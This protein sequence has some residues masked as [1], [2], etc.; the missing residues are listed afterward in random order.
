MNVN[1]NKSAGTIHSMQSSNWIHFGYPYTYKWTKER[2]EE[3][4]RV[5][6]IE[7]NRAALKL[8]YEQRQIDGDRYTYIPK[9]TTRW[10][11][12]KK[13]WKKKKENRWRREKRAHEESTNSRSLCEFSL[14]KL[15][16]YNYRFKGINCFFSV[17]SPLCTNR[18]RAPLHID[19]CTAQHILSEK[20]AIVAGTGA[21][22]KHIYIVTTTKSAA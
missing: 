10:E 5:R 16:R 2:K 17:L 22:E 20:S 12:C 11:A 19:T 14:F 3:W 6:G 13:N 4:T 8:K 1:S 9:S 7:K 18:A 21:D 15:H